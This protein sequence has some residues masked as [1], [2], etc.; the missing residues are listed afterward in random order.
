MRLSLK[1][2]RSRLMRWYRNLTAMPCNSFDTR[3]I[4][5]SSLGRLI[6]STMQLLMS[7]GSDWKVL[8][9]DSTAG[10]LFMVFDASSGGDRAIGMICSDI[11]PS[12]AQRLDQSS[13]Q[14]VSCVNKRGKVA[15]TADA[16]GVVQ[17][18]RALRFNRVTAA[19]REQ[20]D[21]G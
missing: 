21:P 7:C 5:L 20:E 11:L 16:V 2:P 4:F 12:I 6:C 3:H 18:C 15:C 13:R 14:L 19:V 8:G 10:G 17:C 1:L 9:A